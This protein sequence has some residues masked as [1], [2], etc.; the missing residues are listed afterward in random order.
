[1]CSMDHF[2]HVAKKET[3]RTCVDFCILAT[4]S[5]GSGFLS[6]SVWLLSAKCSYRGLTLI[7]LQRIGEN[8]I[9]ETDK[10]GGAIELRRVVHFPRDRKVRADFG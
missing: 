5:A 1:M 6:A 8:S 7:K 10:R 2:P 9:E 4:G 3:S